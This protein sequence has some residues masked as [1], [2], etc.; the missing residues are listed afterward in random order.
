MWYAME[1][2]APKT[3]VLY[4]VPQAFHQSF[5]STTFVSEDKYTNV[6]LADEMRL[7]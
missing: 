3:C 6:R 5:K 2:F 1:L 4:I 7:I